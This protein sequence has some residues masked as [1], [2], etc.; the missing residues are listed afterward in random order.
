L[1][2][3]IEKWE[4]DDE[5]TKRRTR[6]ASPGGTEIRLAR[7]KKR[8]LLLVYPLDA[9]YAGFAAGTSPVMGLAISFPKSKNAKE[10][11]YTVNNVFTTQGGDDDSF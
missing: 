4:K 7:D 6:P 11:T 2:L 1:A 5:Q 9:E 10:V 8:G 3:T